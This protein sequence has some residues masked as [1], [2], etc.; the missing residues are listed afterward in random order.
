MMAMMA[1]VDNLLSYIYNTNKCVHMCRLLIDSGNDHDNLVQFTAS[2]QYYCV[3]GNIFERKFCEK[4]EMIW[5]L[6][7]SSH[8]N[9]ES[10]IGLNIL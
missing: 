10:N 8:F 4:L 1:R 7:P 6:K 5:D 9:C 2:F 3:T